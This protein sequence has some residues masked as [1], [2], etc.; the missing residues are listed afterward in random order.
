LRDSS[1]QLVIHEDDVDGLSDGGQ[2]FG[3]AV[4]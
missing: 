4:L 3:R 2:R 1:G